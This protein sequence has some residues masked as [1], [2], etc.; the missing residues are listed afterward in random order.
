MGTGTE[1]KISR[2]IAKSEGAA[3]SKIPQMRK[4]LWIC[5]G[6][7]VGWFSLNSGVTAPA[8]LWAHVRS[9]KRSR[10]IAKAEGAAESKSP[11]LWKFLRIC[12]SADTVALAQKR[13]KAHMRSLW[14]HLHCC[15]NGKHF[16]RWSSKSG[17]RRSRTCVVEATPQKRLAISQMRKG[18]G[19]IYKSRVWSSYSHFEIW[20]SVL[21]GFR[22]GFH[23]MDWGRHYWLA[24]DYI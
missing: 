13:G 12:E 24:F 11:Q 15:R 3:G 10:G 21:G 1:P 18:L 8:E 19:K 20:S 17:V 22:E 6:V 4:F 23:H 5:E 14:S 7:D 16:H 2:G 9:R